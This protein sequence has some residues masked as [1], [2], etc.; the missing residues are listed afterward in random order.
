MFCACVKWQNSNIIV[1]T[2]IIILKDTTIQLSLQEDIT[3]YTFTL[4]YCCFM[5]FLNGDVHTILHSPASES[6]KGCYILSCFGQLFCYAMVLCTCSNISMTSSC[7][8]Y[9]VMWY[10]SLILA[11]SLLLCCVVF[12]GHQPTHIL[13]PAESAAIAYRPVA[14]GQLGI[15]GTRYTSSPGAYQLTTASSTT[16]TA[17]GTLQP[18]T[19]FQTQSSPFQYIAATPNPQNTGYHTSATFQPRPVQG[20]AYGLQPVAATPVQTAYISPPRPLQ[21]PAVG[22][23]AV[24]ST[25]APAYS[26][27]QSQQAQERLPNPPSYSPQETYSSPTRHWNPSGYP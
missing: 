26:Q 4:C 16:T 19:H 17:A 23:G 14:A 9:F 1:H 27:L 2:T 5:L 22:Y 20:I 6:S 11:V 7:V 25:N 15:A 24:V 21:Q 12:T 3:I 18:L 13:Y 8:A 10:T